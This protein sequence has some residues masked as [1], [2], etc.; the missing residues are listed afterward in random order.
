LIHSLDQFSY[1]ILLIVKLN[2]ANYDQT[3]TTMDAESC[4][5]PYALGKRQEQSDKKRAVVLKAARSQLESGGYRSLTMDSLARE[6]DVTRQTV[7]NLF[8]TKAGVLEALFDELALDGGMERMAEVMRSGMM[9][10]DPEVMLDGFVAVFTGFWRK[11]RMLIR[12]I[13]GIAA[14]D[15]ELGAAVEARNQRRKKAAARIVERIV[16][17]LDAPGMST[18]LQ[19]RQRRAAALYAMT[20]F[21]FFDA[22]AE[23][24]SDEQQAAAALPILVRDMLNS[25]L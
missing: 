4:K 1:L 13:H 12:R 22:L 20:S 11:D 2:F 14:I 9:G 24:Y 5:R 17:R 25:R 6:S 19:D 3:M 16:I 8:K 7:H 15:P 18:E 10:G 23:G 21:E